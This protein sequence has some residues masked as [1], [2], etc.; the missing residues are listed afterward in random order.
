MS[1]ARQETDPLGANKMFGW[2]QS[3][4]SFTVPKSLKKS[5]KSFASGIIADESSD[6]N[7]DNVVTKQSKKA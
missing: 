6:L 7:C 3:N 2:I 4:S 5:L 1:K